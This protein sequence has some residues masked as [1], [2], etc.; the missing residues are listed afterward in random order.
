ME[1]IKI[2][3]CLVVSKMNFIFHIWH[4][5]LPIDFH[6]FQDTYCTTNQIKSI[7]NLISRGYPLDICQIAIENGPVEIVDLPIKNGDFL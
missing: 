4:V 5:I 2:Y 7:E 1:H 3:N 6:I